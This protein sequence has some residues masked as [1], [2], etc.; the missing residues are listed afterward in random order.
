MQCFVCSVLCF[1]FCVQCAVFCVQCAVCSAQC[2]VCSVVVGVEGSQETLE[3]EGRDS[4]GS[5]VRRGWWHNPQQSSQSSQSSAIFTMY[6]KLPH[7]LHNPQQSLQCTTQFSTQSTKNF[8]TIMTILTTHKHLNSTNPETTER[9]GSKGPLFKRYSDR[10]L[11]HNLSEYSNWF[12]SKA[13]FYFKLHFLLL[14]ATFYLL[15]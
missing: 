7:N 5:L 9:L 6:Q 14:F 11:W 8:L 13:F 1:V 3:T 12:H 4:K 2:A 10:I 15:D